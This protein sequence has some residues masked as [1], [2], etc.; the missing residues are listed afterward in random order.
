MRA[1]GETE[2][3]PFYQASVEPG[4]E[5][6][7]EG[8]A[9]RLGGILYLIN[10]LDYLELPDCFEPGWGLASRLG[11]WALLEALARALLEEG[12][13]DC[14]GDPI[15]RALAQLDGR[16]EGS[17]PGWNFQGGDGY[18]IPESWFQGIIPQNLP[19]HW[20]ADPG[21]LRVWSAL[22]FILADV[23]RGRL[24]AQRQARQEL[25]RY[26]DTALLLPADPRDAPLATLAPELVGPLNRDLGRWLALACPYLG[27]RLDQTL[28]TDRHAR[29][30]WL[31]VPGW[32]YVTPTHVDLV[33]S[34][35]AIS[36]PVRLAG[37][38]R[39]PGWVG[40]LGRVVSFHFR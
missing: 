5:E 24:P 38:D 25:G 23:P 29:G 32:L 8:L 16:E 34:L 4:S 14:H 40:R 17:L 18:R 9:T 26:T 6:L 27:W 30:E 37:L 13:E 20:A 15:W 31:R 11:G 28:E 10:L 7:G 21:R 2:G 35:E 39:N 1:P 36:L 12:L 22:G 3:R 33:T 19:W